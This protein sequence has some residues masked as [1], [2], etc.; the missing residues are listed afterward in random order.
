MTAITHSIQFAD[1][2]TRDDL[3]NFLT[4]LSRIGEGEIRVQRRG[5]VLAVY[6]CTQSPAG[7]LDD[8][9]VVL[10]M[11]T[12]ELTETNDAE[13][14]TVFEVR[15]FT[16][17]LAR[18]TGDDLALT[19]PDVTVT[20]AWAGVLPPKSG[21]MRSGV[22]DAASLAS[23]AEQGMA[24]V[25]ESVPSDAGDPVVQK[26]RRLVWSSEIAPG[27]PAAAA[28]AA[29]GLGFLVGVDRM[30][31][32]HANSWTR[33]SSPNGHVILRHSKGIVG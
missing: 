4:R 10:V 11:R 24:R 15:A 2:A 27:I 20:A 29:E 32:T 1:R 5:S 19:L 17:R 33:L 16:D 25:A 6:G 12:C 7:I 31:L 23:V 14:D 9:P 21:W 13:I 22:V 18:L 8:S 30:L 26:V 3:Q 28:F